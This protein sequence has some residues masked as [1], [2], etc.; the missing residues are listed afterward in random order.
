M[1]VVGG[2]EV[3]VVDG[4]ISIVVAPLFPTTTFEPWDTLVLESADRIKKAGWS[5]FDDVSRVC[6][7]LARRWW[8]SLNHATTGRRWPFTV[9]PYYGRCLLW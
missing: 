3:E 6:W 5:G 9:Y 8:D 2:I 4:R 7:E 1:A